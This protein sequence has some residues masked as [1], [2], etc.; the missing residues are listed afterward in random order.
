MQRLWQPVKAGFRSEARAADESG[1][2]G[3]AIVRLPASSKA[4]SDTES[5]TEGQSGSQN[6]P[7]PKT[8][9]EG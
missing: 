7:I 2:E 6:R 4:E 8:C 9:P 3:G 1:A 5:G